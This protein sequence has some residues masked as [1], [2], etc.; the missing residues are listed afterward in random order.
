MLNFISL[1]IGILALLIGIATLIIAIFLH[2]K[3]NKLQ[4]YFHD[5]AKNFSKKIT[6]L[7]IKELTGSPDDIFMIEDK[8]GNLYTGR[9]IIRV[10]NET[11]EVKKENN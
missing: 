5:E 1:V 2:K 9:K 7:T 10:I 3:A 4:E 6:A 8:D 11:I